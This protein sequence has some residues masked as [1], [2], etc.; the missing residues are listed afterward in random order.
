MLSNDAVTGELTDAAIAEM[1]EQIGS[2]QKVDSWVGRVDEDA[3][4]HFALGIGDDNP[5]WWNRE[6]AERAAGGRRYALP[7]VLYA[8][9]TDV[10]RPGQPVKEGGVEGWL[11]GVGGLWAGDRWIWHSR[12]WVGEAVAATSELH[13]VREVQGRFAGRTVVQ[14][15][16]VLFRGGDG[17]Q[18]AELY[19]TTLRFE[20]AAGSGGKSTSD[21]PAPA[22]YTQAERDAIAQQYAREP[23]QRRGSEP[24]WWEDV[25]IGDGLPVVVKGPLTITNLVGW[26]LG[27]GSSQCPTNRMLHQ[28]LA[29]HPGGLLHNSREGIDDTLE[30]VHF[31]EGL[32]Q[33]TGMARGCDFGGQRIAWAGHVL[34]DWCGDDGELVGLD[35]RLKAPNYLGD[36]TWFNGHVVAKRQDEAGGLVDCE[37]NGVNQ[38]GETT[39]TASATVR[40]PTRNL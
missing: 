29:Q 31:D 25:A 22:R 38:R 10:Q 21:W 27:W 33:E 26:L 24:R 39:I 8:V 16:R 6:Y 36:T 17:R 15:E 2:V 1:R 3:L 13:Q 7:T 12:I 20:R 18:V 9:A 37:V 23:G 32:A 4:W 34:T 5:L 40:L 11:P 14:T 28:W 35:A 19:R 30:A